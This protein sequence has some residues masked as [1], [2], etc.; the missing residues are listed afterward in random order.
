MDPLV[1]KPLQPLPGENPC[2]P[3]Y[4]YPKHRPDY[5]YNKLEEPAPP[6]LKPSIP[7]TLPPVAP[8]PMPPIAIPMPIPFP[9]YPMPMF[10]SAVPQFMHPA[11]PQFLPPPV[12]QI[13]MPQISVPYGVPLAANP[14][15]PMPISAPYPY[16]PIP[17]QSGLV[18]G[19]PG[20]VSQDG[21]INILPFSDA[22]SDMLEKHKQ[23]MIRKRLQK[24]LDDYDDFPRRR[25]R[26]KY[27]G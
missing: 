19:I 8:I 22:Y 6:K 27:R 12:A 24:I 21:G 9:M 26:R 2:N 15:M 14:M 18:P 7:Q 5:C 16:P 4:W 3:L 20:L 13:P 17:Q 11:P 25:Q 23:K 1:Q 10:P